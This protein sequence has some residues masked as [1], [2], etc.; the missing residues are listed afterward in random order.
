MNTKEKELLLLTS[1]ISL[2]ADQDSKLSSLLSDKL[3]WSYILFW[4]TKHKIYGL[5]WFHISRLH[6]FK[7]VDPDIGKLLRLA[8]GANIEKNNYYLDE[9]EKILVACEEKG[10]MVIALKGALFLG[11]LYTNYG[12]RSIYDLDLLIL[13]NDKNAFN[14]LLLSMGYAQCKYDAVSDEFIFPSRKEKLTWD[15]YYHNLYPL[16]KKSDNACVGSFEIGGHTSITW[17]QSKENYNVDLE[18]LVT[19]CTR[20]DRYKAPFYS[21]SA[22]DNILHLCNHL[23]QHAAALERLFDRKD[24]YVMF[25]T[26]IREYILSNKATLSWQILAQRVKLYNLERPV[27]YALFFLNDLFPDTISENFLEE[28]KPDDIEYLEFY[29]ML[30]LEVPLKWSQPFKE[31]LFSTS[32]YDEFDSNVNKEDIR[33]LID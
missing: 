32:R 19:R 18:E 14:E 3:D 22:E 4:A 8:Y 20:I 23:Y 12:M 33:A 30:D 16:N 17:G 1:Q 11:N 15:I 26:D 10:I 2:T 21:L 24:L 7:R 28:I 29:G 31:R 9:F 27:Y 13:P 5:L 6:L 25:F